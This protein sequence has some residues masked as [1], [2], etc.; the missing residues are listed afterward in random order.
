MVRWAATSSVKRAVA[1][2]MSPA[3]EIAPLSAMPFTPQAITCG[4]SSSVM[5]PMA[6]TGSRIPARAI[7]RRMRR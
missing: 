4:T 2:A 7:C 5:P 3:R 1:A 6:A